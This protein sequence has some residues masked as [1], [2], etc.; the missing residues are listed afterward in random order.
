MFSVV[1]ISSRDMG[2]A[3]LIAAALVGEKLAAC[4]NCWPITS[5]FR[6]EGALEESA[7]VAL[8]C[9]TRTD[10]VPQ[11]IRRVKELHSY[12]VPCITSWKIDA[13]SAEYLD[14]VGRET[15]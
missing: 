12:G 8:I 9:K 14:W 13:G 4:V 6:W 3:R 11:V 10:L 5:V 2:E 15:R 1:Y 7:E